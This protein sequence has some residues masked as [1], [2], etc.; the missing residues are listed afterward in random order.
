M[1]FTAIIEKE[2]EHFVAHCP[3]LDISS[4]GETIEDARLM[5]KEAI[6]LFWDEASDNEKQQR[7]TREYLIENFELEDA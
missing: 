5:L 3:E 6:E 2:D 4:Q 1:K 7:I